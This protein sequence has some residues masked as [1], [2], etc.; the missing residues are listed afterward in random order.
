MPGP[1]DFLNETID[2]PDNSPWRNL[3]NAL[4]NRYPALRDGTGGSIIAF[5]NKVIKT[6]EFPRRMAVVTI[7]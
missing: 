5:L 1:T 4:L 3:P 7:L 2:E 6:S